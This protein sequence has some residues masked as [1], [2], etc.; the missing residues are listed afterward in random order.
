MAKNSEL[1]AS[2]VM[3]MAGSAEVI[4]LLLAFLIRS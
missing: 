4:T 2:L 3:K 1:V